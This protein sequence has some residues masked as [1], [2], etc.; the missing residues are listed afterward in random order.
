[1]DMD[2]AAEDRAPLANGVNLTLT[3]VASLFVMA[4]IYSC[5]HFLQR[6]LYLEEWLIL[7]SIILISISVA[8]M[9]AGFYSGLGRHYDTLTLD[10]KR[11]ANFWH[12]LG[13]APS[14]YGVA[15]PKISVV[16]LC[17]CPDQLTTGINT[18]FCLRVAAASF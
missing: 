14:I 15:M 1:M 6:R 9:T 3:A 7:I 10:E 11:R 2:R 4:R 16:S 17:E 18:S 12:V 8:F 5:L 13:S